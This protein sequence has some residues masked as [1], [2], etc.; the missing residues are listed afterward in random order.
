MLLVRPQQ[1]FSSFRFIFVAN[2]KA[3]IVYHHHSIRSIL[4]CLFYSLIAFLTYAIRFFFL[5]QY[6]LHFFSFS[7]VGFVF[8]FHFFLLLLL[9]LMSHFVSMFFFSLSM[10]YV[11][12]CFIAYKQPESV[13]L[14]ALFY[15]LVC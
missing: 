7:F 3:N 1:Y 5:L 11:L 12:H 8:F 13:L 10:L 2:A 6:L 4:L 9:L 15:K 14:F